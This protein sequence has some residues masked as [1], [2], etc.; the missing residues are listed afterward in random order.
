MKKINL[1]DIFHNKN[2]CLLLISQLCSNVA[3]TIILFSVINIVFLEVGSSSVIALI[4]ILY[5]LPGTFLG[6]LAGTVVDKVNKRRVFLISNL[7]Q[8]IIALF[9][10]AIRN[11]IFLA[12]PLVLFYSLFDELFNP[13]MGAV[14]PN[15]VKKENLGLANTF[16]FF[17]AQ[18]SIILGSLI[19]GLILS[20]TPNYQLVFPLVSLMLIGGVV[21]IILVPEN[22]LNHKKTLKKAWEDFNPEEFLTDIRDS[23][24]FLKNNKLVLFP[25]LFLALI[26]TFIGAAISIAPVLAQALGVP[27]TSASLSIVTPGIIGAIIGGAWTSQIIKKG[28]LRKK[29]LIINGLFCSG[30]ALVLIFL[31]SL[32]SLAPYL[33]WILLIGLGAS[34]I[35][36]VIPAKTLIQEH[37]PFEIRGRVYGIL[38]MLIALA[39]MLPLLLVASLV[40][41]I[42]VKAVILITGLILIGLGVFFNKKQGL[43]FQKIEQS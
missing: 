27:I 24:F 2:F 5:Y 23:L 25:I 42:G 6:I 41:L 33:V 12:F 32:S 29:S 22:F 20:L 8:A 11:Q 4:T 38:N 15:V 19:S 36:T 7:S 31:A 1:P 35:L 13:A 14:L 17:A 9:F 26:Q 21:A 40:D 30:I 37:S 43:I 39:G 3:A 18:G 28:Q 10:L 16:W 34:F